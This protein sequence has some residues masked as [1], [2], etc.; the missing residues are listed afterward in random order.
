MF[1]RNIRRSINKF[2]YP[3][4]V[5]VH[6]G[7]R[8]IELTQPYL[9]NVITE[10][11]LNSLNRTMKNYND[12]KTIGAVM[13]VS[14]SPELFSI[15]TGKT[16]DNKTRLKLVQSINNFAVKISDFNKVTIAIYEGL[17]N[18]MGFSTFATSK[19]SILI[20]CYF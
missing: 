12:N 2:A 11:L 13:F 18:S 16:V 10:D 4:R 8:I 5:I 17:V 9:G 14:N 6:P 7:S 20:N 19:V 1:S 3:E 15:G